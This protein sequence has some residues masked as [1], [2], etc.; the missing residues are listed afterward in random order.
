MLAYNAKHVSASKTEDMTASAMLTPMTLENGPSSAAGDATDVTSRWPTTFWQQIVILTG[1]SFK[2]NRGNVWT[3]VN[4]LQSFAVAFVA[5]GAWFQTGAT[6]V[7]RLV[8][9]FPLLERPTEKCFDA[10]TCFFLTQ[11]SI[12]DRVGYYF[13]TAAYWGFQ[14]L[15]VAT[16][17]RCCDQSALPY[18]RPLRSGQHLCRCA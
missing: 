12:Q 7:R 18:A 17:V 10:S 6:E 3:A 16:Q 8:V 9:Y 15:F 11:D 13:F 4:F 5:G 1:R 14:S 2:Q